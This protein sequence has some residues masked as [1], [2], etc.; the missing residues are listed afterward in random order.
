[1]ACVSANVE[2]VLFV[3]LTPEH[4]IDGLKVSGWHSTLVQG[5]ERVLAKI[6]KYT[7]GNAL[8]N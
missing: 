2:G 6:D 1:M 4:L 7:E 8:L 5:P 3:V